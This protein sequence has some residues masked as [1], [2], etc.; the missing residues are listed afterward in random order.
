MFRCEIGDLINTMSHASQKSKRIYPLGFKRGK[1]YSR[2]ESG[3]RK[4]PRHDR[5]GLL[6]VCDGLKYSIFALIG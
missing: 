2:C 1:T 5:F 6:L 3:K 4:G